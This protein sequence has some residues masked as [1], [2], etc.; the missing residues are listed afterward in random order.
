MSTISTLLNQT[1][2][3]LTDDK[4]TAGNTTASLA[5]ALNGDTKSHAAT[6]GTA[7]VSYLLNLSDEARDYLATQAKNAA[8]GQTDT[9]PAEGFALSNAQQEQ[10]DSIIAKYKDAPFTQESF[11]A[12]LTEIEQAGLGPQTLAAK[13]QVRQLN[14]TQLFLNVMNGDNNLTFGASNNAVQKAKGEAHLQA[15]YDQWENIST[16][17][18]AED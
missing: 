5:S 9:S 8:A 16:T 6:P 18:S 14:T 17:A 11:D 15:I 3:T 7:D 1:Y 12:M 10:L 4:K 2:S 13:D